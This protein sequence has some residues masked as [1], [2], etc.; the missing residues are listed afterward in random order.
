MALH[1]IH[2]TMTGPRRHRDGSRHEEQ[3]GEGEEG[4]TKNT[5]SLK[6]FFKWCF[7]YSL[8]FPFSSP[9]HSFSSSSATSISLLSLLPIIKVMQVPHELDI[10]YK[11][12]NCDLILVDP[13]SNEY[14]VISKCAMATA[15]TRGTPKIIG[16]WQVK[17][18]NVVSRL[19]C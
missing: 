11:S 18:H 13:K 4:K 9:F 7:Y 14:D 1:S 16:M 19:F 6:V 5:N 12:L 8:V 17:Q 2:S 10:H 3:Q 15:Y